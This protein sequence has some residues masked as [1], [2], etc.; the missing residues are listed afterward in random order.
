MTTKERVELAIAVITVSAGGLGWLLAQLR[1]RIKQAVERERAKW[2][3][4]QI[5]NENKDL[6][7]EN[8]EMARDLRKL[9][10]LNK[11]SN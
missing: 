2:E 5:K 7:E 10:G 1:E 4:E 8:K 11:L 3:I 6:K 9:L